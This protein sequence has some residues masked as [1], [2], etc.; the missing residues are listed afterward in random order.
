MRNL[1]SLSALPLFAAAS[2]ARPLQFLEE[3]PVTT[4]VATQRACTQIDPANADRYTRNLDASLAKLSPEDV[5]DT[6]AAPGFDKRVEEMTRPLLAE[7][8]RDALLKR[9]S[10]DSPHP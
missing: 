5:R 6:M 7:G 2:F 10:P 1:A 4:A 9:C 8:R 3:L